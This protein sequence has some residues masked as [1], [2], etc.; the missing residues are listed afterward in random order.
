MKKVLLFLSLIT[1]A[2]NSFGQGLTNAS[3]ENWTSFTSTGGTGEYPTGWTTTDSIG[4]ANGGLTSAWRGT[5]PFDGANSLHLKTSQVTIF[6]PITGPAIATNGKV[7][8]VGANFVFSGGSPEVNRVRYY[9][10]QFKYNP[11]ANTDSA[12]VSALL[13]R[14]NGIKRDTV[15]L[16]TVTMS[17]A[18]VYTPFLVKMNYIDFVNPPDS[19]LILVQSSK[20]TLNGPTV[21]L[22]SELTVDSISTV[23][24]VGIDEASDVIRSISVYPTPANDHITVTADLVSTQKLSYDIFDN[25]GRWVRSGKMETTKEMIEVADLTVGQYVLKLNGNGRPIAAKSFTIAR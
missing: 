1:F 23:G 15:A 16:G 11:A 9:T 24:T 22:N 25:N 6:I 3:F 12:Y 10:G 19:C 4:K 5:D 20:G 21:A 14:W 17:A 8:L 2:F 13:C 18:T 7:N